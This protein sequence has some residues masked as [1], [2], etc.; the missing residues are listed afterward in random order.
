MQVY[1]AFL[2]LA[3]RELG[4]QSK[5]FFFNG[6]RERRSTRELQQVRENPSRRLARSQVLQVFPRVAA[7]KD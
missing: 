6:A 2:Q 3:R 5:P 7:R 4:E 1:P